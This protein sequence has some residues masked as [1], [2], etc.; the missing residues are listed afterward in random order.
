M[1]VP[2]PILRRALALAILAAIPLVLWLAVIGP[3]WDSFGDGGDTEVRSLKLIA[4]LRQ[5][6][7]QRPALE[8]EIKALEARGKALPGYISGNTTA[9]AAATVQSEVKR[10]VE[11]RGGQVRSTQDLAPTRDH[12]VEKI[13]VR[14]D[15]TISLEA[16]PAIVYEIESHGPYLF[17]DNL[18]IRAPEDARPETYV[19]NKPILII[20]WDVFGY[21]PMGET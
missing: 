5:T 17:I 4:S 9:L 8:T 19:A 21:R 14:F 1:S 20:R 2:M 13:G 7:A 6:A 12:G 10:I 15:M 11:S 3:I 18:E 16:L